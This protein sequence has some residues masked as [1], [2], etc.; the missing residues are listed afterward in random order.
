MTRSIPH[1]LESLLIASFHPRLSWLRCTQGVDLRHAARLKRLKDEGYLDG[2]THVI[3][4]GANVG[5]YAKAMSFV[6][7]EATIHCFEPATATFERLRQNTA[8][9]RNVRA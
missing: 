5:S 1:S 4:A 7:P 9:L 8:R 6:L 2:V 3:D